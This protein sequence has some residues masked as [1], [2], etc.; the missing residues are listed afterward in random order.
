MI[1]VKSSQVKY[2]PV[3]HRPSHSGRPI[4]TQSIRAPG[5]M[6]FPPPSLTSSQ[7]KSSSGASYATVGWHVSMMIMTRDDELFYTVSVIG[8]M[9]H[10]MRNE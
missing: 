5:F 3:G 1:S 2:V 6:H 10:I 9:F 4:R 7:V 8:Q